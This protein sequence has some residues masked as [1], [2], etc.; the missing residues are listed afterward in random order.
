MTKVALREFFTHEG[1]PLGKKADTKEKL[2]VQATELMKTHPN[3]YTRLKDRFDNAVKVSPI[4]CE[5]LVPNS[6]FPR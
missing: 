3:H 2:L 5:I 6:V 4:H 1:I